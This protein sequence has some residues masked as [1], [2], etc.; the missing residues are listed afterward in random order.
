M[1]SPIDLAFIDGD[2]ETIAVLQDF[3]LLWPHLSPDAADVFHDVKT[4]STVRQAILTLFKD[5]R[6]NQI[7]R[8]FEFTPSGV[9]ALGMVEIHNK[10]P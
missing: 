10:R 6:L 2:H 1:L 9:D 3:M 5:N 7:L 4:W 8:Y